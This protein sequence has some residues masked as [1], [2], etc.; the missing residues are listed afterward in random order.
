[1]PKPCPSEGRLRWRWCLAVP[2]VAFAQLVAANGPDTAAQEPIIT[3]VA[4]SEAYAAV[5]CLKRGYPYFEMV[6]REH[7]LCSMNQTSHLIDARAYLAALK[8]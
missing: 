1:M 8:P 2:F 6:G 7:A 5:E 4:H 3:L